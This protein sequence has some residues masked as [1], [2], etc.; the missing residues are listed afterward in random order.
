MHPPTW[1]RDH[2]APFDVIETIS[3]LGGGHWQYDYTFTNS[4]PDAIWN[5]QIYT[6]WTTS[7]P[8]A[9]KSGT[10]AA[11]FSVDGIVA[12]YDPRNIEPSTLWVSH[13]Y[14][15]DWSSAPYGASAYAI[16][17]GE[18]MT[19]FGFTARHIRPIRQAVRPTT[20]AQ[21]YA[22]YSKEVSAYGYTAPTPEPVT[23][24]LLACSG[25][26]G[27]AVRRKRRRVVTDPPIATQSHSTGPPLSPGRPAMFHAPCRFPSRSSPAPVS[28]GRQAATRGLPVNTCHRWRTAP[29]WTPA[30]IQR[31]S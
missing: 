6:D 18:T 15:T 11:D 3:D 14:A 17:S 4:D 23:L 1:Y 28:G 8:T 31:S 2:P 7:S 29:A 13:F 22:Y 10:I 21:N 16:Q 27:F 20:R 30:G 19:G 5:F 9:P 24:V 25:L 26:V 12:P